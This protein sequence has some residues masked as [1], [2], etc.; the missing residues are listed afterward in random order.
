MPYIR[1]VKISRFRAILTLALAFSVTLPQRQALATPAPLPASLCETSRE[2]LSEA[3]AIRGLKVLNQV[4]CIVQDKPLV[5]AFLHETIN[6]ELP[7]HKIQMEELTFRTVGL[8]PEDFDYGRQLV[9]FLVSQIGGYYDPKKKHFVMAAWLPG[10]VQHGVAVHELTHALQDQ[11]YG[12]RKLLNPQAGTTDSDIATSALIEGD[13]SAVMFDDQ[14]RRASKLKLQDLPSVDSLLLIQVLGLNFGAE[15]GE[16]PDALKGLL[17]FPYTSGL[18]FAHALLRHGGYA[19]IDKAYAK[20]PTTSRQILH[21]DEFLSA[22][23]TPSIPEVS[24]LA[25]Y[26][27]DHQPEY[28]DTLGEFA[29]SAI[30]SSVQSSKSDAAT[31]ARGWV[32]DRLGI[33]PA[34]NGERLISWVTRWESDADAN[35]FY[36]AYKKMLEARYSLKQVDGAA[37]PIQLTSKKAVRISRSARSVSL[38]FI[39]Q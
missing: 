38:Q 5:E 18:R 28:L 37:G 15:G 3:S 34:Q 25:G 19:A 12:L 7:P 39:S 6:S 8:I 17:I 10:P 33:F 21:P 23:F 36:S 2:A 31:A 24:E 13:A 29:I 32:G 14:S 9:G 1:N 22:S 30:L 35:E 16:V 4:P 11:H 26:S 27:K 20:P